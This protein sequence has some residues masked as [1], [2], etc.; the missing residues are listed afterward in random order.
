MILSSYRFTQTTKGRQW[1]YVLLI[2]LSLM[3]SG[4][5][6][7]YFRSGGVPPQGPVRYSLAEWPFEEYWT[8]IVCG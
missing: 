2:L 7:M 6:W 3:Q 4:C 8:G 1:C 5:A